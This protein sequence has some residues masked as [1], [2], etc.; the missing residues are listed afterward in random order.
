[1][2]KND[3]NVYETKFKFLYIIINRMISG[4]KNCS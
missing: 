2:Q 1:M 3:W 4:R